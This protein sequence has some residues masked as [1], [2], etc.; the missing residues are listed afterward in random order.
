CYCVFS[1]LPSFPTRRS[2]DLSAFDLVDL[3]FQSRLESRK[4][5]RVRMLAFLASSTVKAALL[6]NGASL[7]LIG[8]ACLLDWVF[9]GVALALLYARH[10]GWPDFRWPEMA[11]VRN[12]LSESYV[13][14]VA[15][16]SGLAFMKLD[17]IM[18]QAMR[19][20]AEVAIMAVS[21]RLT[22]A[23][24]FVPAALV[25]STFPVIVRLNGT[26]PDL[27]VAR[28]QRLYREVAWLSIAAAI[29]ISLCADRLIVLLYGSAYQAAATVLVIQV[30]CGILMSFG[31]ASGAWLIAQKRGVV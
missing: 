16:F 11:D 14:I 12:L 27:A 29:G 25:A 6:W 19:D 22:E 4:V 8:A 31:I 1:A 30:W 23:W 2:S 3:L 7:L 15:G 13:E 21:S 17:Q 28:I 26:S 20:P 9:V 18:L 10:R 24:Y 5:A